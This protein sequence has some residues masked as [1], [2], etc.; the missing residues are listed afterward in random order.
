VHRVLISTAELGELLESDPRVRLVDVRGGGEFESGHIPGSYNVPLD[1]LSEHQR[2]L[3]ELGEPVVLVCR[4][5]ARAG[6]AEQALTGAGLDN[7]R[8]L[9]G[10]IDAWAADGREVVSIADRWP[11]DRQVRLV[12]GAVVAASIVASLRFPRLKWIAGG[13][14][15][16]LAVAA[17][18]DSCA[19][20]SV[21]ARLPYNRP[22][23]CDTARV[24]EQLRHHSNQEVAA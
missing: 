9:R 20:A 3:V 19:M 2:D 21:L 13:V 22:I 15:A 17:L 11:M 6:H 4:S 1:A 7:V 5:G 23:A 8:V 18:T 16:G 12:A 14:G 24:V 10:G